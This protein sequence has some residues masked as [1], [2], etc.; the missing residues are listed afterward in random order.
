MPVDRGLLSMAVRCLPSP[1]K[2]QNQR[3]SVFCPKL[4]TMLD[5]PILKGVKEAD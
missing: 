1:I 4:E 2:A 3:V 5:S